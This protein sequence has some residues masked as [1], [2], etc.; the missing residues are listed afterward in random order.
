MLFIKFSNIILNIK[1]GLDFDKN[2]KIKPR[3]ETKQIFKPIDL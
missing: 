1:P 3:F 2:K